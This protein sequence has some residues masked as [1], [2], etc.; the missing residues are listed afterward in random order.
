MSEAT[1]TQKELF[2][3]S[4]VL[5]AETHDAVSIANIQSEI[6]RCIIAEEGNDPLSYDEISANVASSYQYHIAED[7]IIQAISRTQ[8]KV[9]EI[10][11]VNGQET[12][13]LTSAAY[14]QT[15]E[16]MEKNINYYIDLFISEH[17][18]LD[19]EK[20]KYAMQKYLYELTTS[21]INSY[22]V[23]LGKTDGSQFS[24][25]EL[26]V[27][28]RDL[29]DSE[30][31]IVHDFIEWDNMEKNVALSNIVLCCL[32]YCLLINGDQANPLVKKIIRNRMVFLDTNII[33][34]ALGINGIPRKNVIIAFLNKCKQAN[35][36]LVILNKTEEEF[37]NAISYYIGEIQK[38]PRGQVFFGSIR[39]AFRL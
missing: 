10:R 33:F 15:S 16:S 32:E 39:N 38:H 6:I 8:G 5:Y 18:E 29:N 26:S 34:R 17:E 9:F 12:V 4:A 20:C 14:K 30:R 24:G 31:A 25:S 22:K 36:Q 13:K 19:G 21:N 1:L 3:L 35:I 11:K 2:R 28:V 27:D 37:F 23:L 7:E